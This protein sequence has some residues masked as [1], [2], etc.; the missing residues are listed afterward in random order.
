MESSFLSLTVKE[1][2]NYLQDRGIIVGD[3]RRSELIFLC[4]AAKTLDLEKDPDG[5]MEDG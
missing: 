5:L 1:L 3:K 4:E 2:K